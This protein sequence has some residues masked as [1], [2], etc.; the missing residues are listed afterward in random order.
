MLSSFISDGDCKEILEVNKNIEFVREAVKKG[1]FFEE[2]IEKYFLNNP[3]HIKVLM[4]SDENFTQKQVDKEK[5]ELKRIKANLKKEDLEKIQEDV[6]Y[7]YNLFFNLLY[8]VVF[9]YF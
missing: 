4:K 2:L 7:I 6:V 9:I 5:E 3:H 1:R 8:L